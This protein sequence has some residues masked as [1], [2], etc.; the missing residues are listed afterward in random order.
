M[1]SFSELIKTRHST[2]KFTKEELTQDEVVS[3]LQA[4]LSAPSSRNRKCWQFIAVDEKTTLKE[5]SR[6]KESS[7]S[8]IAEAPL[9][10]VVLA[11]PLVSDVWME[12]AAIAA[13][14]LQ[15]QA[16]DLGLGSCWVQVMER[17][18]SDDETSNDYVHG[19]LDI[20]RQLQVVSIIAI[21]HKDIEK[22]KNIEREPQWEK[23]HINKYGGE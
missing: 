9:A 3:L 7:A 18:Y 23:V 6:C 20:P 10:V 8:F 16:E 17:M 19:I 22:E 11:D 21:G 12:D 15:L 2:R 14:Y 4:A 1:K 13:T 5:L